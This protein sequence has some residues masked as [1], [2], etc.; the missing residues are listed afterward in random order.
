MLERT[1]RYKGRDRGRDKGIVKN[2]EE[3]WRR[4]GKIMFWRE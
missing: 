2:K 3:G 4:E 1:Q